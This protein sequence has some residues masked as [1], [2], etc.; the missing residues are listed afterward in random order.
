MT[1]R[2]DEPK[3]LGFS[4]SSSYYNRFRRHFSLGYQSPFSLRT[5]VPEWPGKTETILHFF[6]CK[7]HLAAPYQGEKMIFRPLYSPHPLF[8]TRTD[9]IGRDQAPVLIIDNFCNDAD[10][11]VNSAVKAFTKE[12]RHRDGFPGI[13]SSAD[14]TFARSAIRHLMPMI[15]QSFGVS[16]KI[17]SGGFDYQIMTCPP[18][19]LSPRQT[20]PHYDV[21]DMDVLASVLYLCHPLLIIA[22]N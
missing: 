1:R 18:S 8:A 20:K 15:C 12:S 16:G 6:P 21:A 22:K 7:P 5:N 2:S 3:L 13:V 17:L 9:I 11:L 4:S 19:E 10:F 14:E